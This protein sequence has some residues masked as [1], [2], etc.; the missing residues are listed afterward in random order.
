MDES[1]RE[2]RAV[3]GRDSGSIWP[4]ANWLDNL[5]FGPAPESLEALQEDVAPME[6]RLGRRVRALLA[7]A[8]AIRESSSVK[9]AA[10]LHEA[11][12]VLEKRAGRPADAW[13][14]HSHAL[15]IMPEHKP[16]RDALR[17]LAR[18]SGDMELLGQLIS[19]QIGRSAHPA[20]VSVLLT[21]LGV[22]EHLEG[23]HGQAVD[24]LREAMAA[25]PD[26]LA[27]LLLMLSVAT[28]EEDDDEIVQTLSRLVAE[29]PDARMR[30]EMRLVLAL[31]EE[32]AGRLDKARECLE[33]EEPELSPTPPTLWARMRVS[34][35]DGQYASAQKALHELRS[36]LEP[37][38]LREALTRWTFAMSRLSQGHGFSLEAEDP[39]DERFAD[40]EALD[41]FRR[42]VRDRYVSA[43]ASMIREA[44][45][46]SWRSALWLT[47]HVGRWGGTLQTTTGAVV[48]GV[49][50]DS[51]AA[52]AVAGLLNASFDTEANSTNI[53]VRLDPAAM[54]HIS[55]SSGDFARAADDLRRLRERTVESADRWALAVA[56][57][58]LRRGK[59][60]KGDEALATLRSE[61]MDLAREPLG[62][63]VRLEEREAASLAEL[64][65]AESQKT[66]D[67]LRAAWLVAWA[68]KHLESIDG[69][70]SRRLYGNALELSPSNLMALAGLRRLGATHEELVERSIAAANSLE[71][72]FERAEFLVRAAFYQLLSDNP[73]RAAALFGKAYKLAPRD[74]SIWRY[75]LRFA[76]THLRSALSS[77]VL[78]PPEGES[79]GLY[80]ML[81]LGS[82]GL[83]IDPEAAQEWF[84]Q[85][86]RQA[87]EDPIAQKGLI[88]A[89]FDA[90]KSAMVTEKL[91]ERIREAADL[92]EEAAIFLRIA[93]VDRR[94]GEK[95]SAV[96]LSLLAA[97]ERLPGHVSTLTRLALHQAKNRLR[98]ELAKTL[99]CLAAATQ[100]DKDAS[101]LGIAAWHAGRDDLQA[102]RTGVRC[103]PEVALE[104][105]ELEARLEDIEERRALLERIVPRLDGTQTFALRLA[106]ADMD[107]R[108]VEEALEVLQR[109]SSMS[110]VKPVALVELA[111]LQ[112]A[113][114]DFSDL[115]ET[116]ERLADA[117]LSQEHRAE[118]WMQAMSI[119]R[120]DLSD[121]R[122]AARYCVEMLKIDP[123]NEEVFTQGRA[124]LDAATDAELSAALIEARIKGQDDPMERR[125]MHVELV[126]L[127]LRLGRREDAQRQLVA[128]LE[129]LPNDFEHHWM[130]ADFYRD[131]EDYQKAIE[132]F[133]AAAKLSEDKEASQKL[134]FA[135]G[136]LYMDHTEHK[137]LAEKSFLR[138][139]G[140]DKTHGP[141]LE[142]LVSLY[143]RQGNPNRAA[144]ALE[145]L[146]RSAQDDDTRIVKMVQLAHLLQEHLGRP[147]Q[148]ERVLVEATRVDPLDLR[149]FDAL[150][151]LLRRQND[152]LSLGI[153]LDRAIASQA[154]ALEQRPGDASLYRNL[155]KLWASR[156]KAIFVTLAKEALCLLEGA[157]NPDGDEQVH[158][159]VGGRIG[160]AVYED[161]LCPKSVLA[162]LRET[163]KILREPFAQLESVSARDLD[164]AR[165]ARLSR[166]HPL[167]VAAA[168]MVPQFGLQLP[169]FHVS[170]ENEPGV[171]IFPGDPPS[172]VVP[173]AV[174][175]SSHSTVHLF[176]AGF[177]LQIE[178]LGL[179]LATVV[180]PERLRLL[181]AGAV[182]M[183]S[184]GYFLRDMDEAE[185][186][187]AMKEIS[188]FI[189]DEV[190]RRIQPFALD[191]SAALASPSLCRD[192]FAAGYRSGFVAAGSLIGAADGLR[193]FHAD[194]ET[195][196]SRLPGIGSIM[197]FA[198]SRDHAEL[199][200]RLG[201]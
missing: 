59:L 114:G 137:E 104:A 179:G 29:W 25:N 56:E 81:C 106:E 190:R 197:A 48:S 24:A 102:L 132:H 127:L 42:G 162:G 17:R 58:S 199:R 22:I 180:P 129:I 63:L 46:D 150:F 121:P 143:V 11:G 66:A 169:N 49:E 5:P 41:A 35:R 60:Q 72:P 50:G 184:D 156:E 84:S 178:R 185:T 45:S 55:L 74:A 39:E 7:N 75:A 154:A 71:T 126:P 112:K 115:L 161:Y 168:R 3:S 78:V 53:N 95:E 200:K 182:R 153:Q 30:Q 170:V 192:I 148:A 13:V 125:N 51:V 27:P 194:D 160:E 195:A 70:E 100:D 196:L 69:E 73:A 133:V 82:L 77:H 67:D 87:P 103:D 44:K 4:A 181:L 86:A 79:L 110:G 144:Q 62:A 172:V 141:S 96:I 138:V 149:P 147:D 83:E 201:I 146:I 38:T 124:L 52:R 173:H 18:K 142:R 167:V 93:D 163:L 21:E 54:L 176:A 136:E 101:M 183:L 117:V 43:L 191:S 57:A 92:E 105:V 10:C 89:L 171:R 151:E 34:L 31:I 68:A 9:A 64:A 76:M 36:V 135:L 131:D 165:H 26:G 16:S 37:G 15:D 94:F 40:I 33:V 91:I 157:E 111:A 155:E 164:S 120:D 2:R 20:E 1:Y 99:A 113:R 198:F 28:Q 65:V 123:A 128:A 6:H 187:R 152:S 193:A 186:I 166:K 90:G 108:K 80:D 177:A 122:R 130:L 97:A 134:F 8:W 85:A 61:T 23:R 47:E 119:A 109:A 12:R 32:R 14:C 98:K 159:N 139:L 118:I 175:Q 145:H 88:E 158:W 174:A 189:S 188:P 107:C 140:W 116:L 19:A